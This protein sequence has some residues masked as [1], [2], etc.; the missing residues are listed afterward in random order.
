MIQSVQGSTTLWTQCFNLNV[1]MY[2]ICDV[3]NKVVN[4]YYYYY[5]II[6]TVV[7]SNSLASNN[8]IGDIF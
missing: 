2:D 8:D 6:I 5:I 4:Y 1:I 3:P 7:K